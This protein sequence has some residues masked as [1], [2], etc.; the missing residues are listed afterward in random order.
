MRSDQSP[1]R[2]KLSTME[3]LEHY[4]SVR[5]TGERM[6]WL[7]V[8]TVLDDGH[9]PEAVCRTLGM[10]KASMYRQL[11]KQDLSHGRGRLPRQAGHL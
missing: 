1:V 10:S 11:R 8:R 2:G 7:I 9:P 5:D 3:L 4:V 6:L